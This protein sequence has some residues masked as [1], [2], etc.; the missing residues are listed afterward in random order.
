MKPKCQPATPN[1][2]LATWPLSPR[3]FARSQWCFVKK[4]ACEP[5]RRIERYL[6]SLSRARRD[7]DANVMVGWPAGCNHKYTDNYSTSHWFILKSL[8]GSV[9]LCSGLG[10]S[11]RPVV[12]ICMLRTLRR[13]ESSLTRIINESTSARPSVW[14]WSVSRSVNDNT[15]FQALL[16]GLTGW[17]DLER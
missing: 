17:P 2:R 13:A 11:S 1:Q 14:R 4:R 8:T 10:Q 9:R 6:V 5:M 15:R 16:T 3:S 12:Q 7:A